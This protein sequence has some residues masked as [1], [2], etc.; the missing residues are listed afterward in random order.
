MQILSHIGWNEDIISSNWLSTK[1][2][3]QKT[4][5]YTLLFTGLSRVLCRW[6]SVGNVIRIWSLNWTDPLTSSQ[7]SNARRKRLTQDSLDLPGHPQSQTA[8]WC[9]RWWKD[10]WGSSFSNA[11]RTS[12][13]HLCA[14]ACVCVCVCVWYDGK[15]IVRSMRTFQMYRYHWASEEIL[16]N[17]SKA[18]L[19]LL[20]LPTLISSKMFATWLIF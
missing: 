15:E 14:F 20:V 16:P 7:R 11:P 1:A 6:K 10:C 12:Y 8:G 19:S 17:I 4:I 9:H 18:L 2:T 13:T 3:L 5:L